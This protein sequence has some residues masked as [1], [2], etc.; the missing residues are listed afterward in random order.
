[1]YSPDSDK[2][3]DQQVDRELLAARF[4]RDGV[5]ALKRV[6]AAERCTSLLAHLKEELDPLVGPVEF[7]VDVGYPGAPTDR[8]QP[9]GETP[10]RLLHA[11][12]RGGALRDLAE[13]PEITGLTRYLLGADVRLTQ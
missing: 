8:S 12:T 4:R 10:R 9:G 2:D 3:K 5:V 6:V 13:E 1:M 11:Y 7:E